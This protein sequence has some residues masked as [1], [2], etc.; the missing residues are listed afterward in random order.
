MSNHN[1]YF[2]ENREDENVEE[3]ETAV[4]TV[5]NETAEQGGYFT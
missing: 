5:E 4:E 2:I 1:A 3:E